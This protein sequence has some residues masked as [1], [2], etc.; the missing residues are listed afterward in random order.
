VI[1]NI[2]STGTLDAYWIKEY[3]A[4]IKLQYVFRIIWQWHDF[5]TAKRHRFVE[6]LAGSLYSLKSYLYFYIHSYF[7]LIPNFLNYSR[8]FAFGPD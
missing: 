7:L 5:S 2:D 6:Q 4:A 3:L 8:R 1:E